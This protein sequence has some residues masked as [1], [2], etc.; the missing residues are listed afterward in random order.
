[1]NAHSAALLS[2]ERAILACEANVERMR[3]EFMVGLERRS[4][5]GVAPH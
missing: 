3:S 4:V 2:E 1:M 5:G